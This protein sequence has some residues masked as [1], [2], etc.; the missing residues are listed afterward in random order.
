MKIIIFAGGTGTRLWPLSRKNSPKQF[1]KLINGKSTL[2]MAVDRVR[3]VYGLYNIYIQTLEEYVSIVKNQLPELP[4]SNIFA[5]PAKRD[6]A[7]AIGF[8]FMK[9]KK[10]GI[11]EPVAIL[12]SDHLMENVDTFQNGLKAGEKLILEDPNRFV[13]IGERP[14]YAENNLGWINIGRKLEEKHKVP[15][16]E[17]VKWHYRPPVKKCK[18][19]FASGKWTWNPGYFVTSIDFVLSLY[20]KYQ[21]KMFSKLEK[22]AASFDTAE[23]SSIV[24]EIYPTME[25]VHFDTAILENTKPED[26]VVLKID[27][28]W[29]DPGTLYALK[30]ALQESR[31]SNVTKGKTFTLD[32]KDCLVYNEEKD[33][34]VSAVGLEGFVIVNTHDASIVV[35]K[36]RVID[37]KDLVKELQANEHAEFI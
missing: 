26:A 3:D 24:S 11:Q 29:S 7:P 31:E 23:E 32:C 19:M 5:E 18:E 17:F 4:L 36:E 16:Y 6:V 12:W 22:I 33:K 13:Y 10:Q 25:S 2:Q 27:M 21:P 15:I 28:G 8:A 37:V 20:R 14:R 1:D 34:L 35:H 9:L 30:E